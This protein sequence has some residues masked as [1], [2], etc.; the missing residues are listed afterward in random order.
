MLADALAK[1]AL[2]S[3]HKLLILTRTNALKA[4]LDVVNSD[5]VVIVVLDV[6]RR[7]G[8]DQLNPNQPADPCCNH[9]VRARLTYS[10]SLCS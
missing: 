1:G 5:S 3:A 4:V 9:C 6:V 2:P 8:D 7:D 10:V